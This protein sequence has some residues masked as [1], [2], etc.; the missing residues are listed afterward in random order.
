MTEPSRA[1]GSPAAASFRLYF[2]PVLLAILNANRAALQGSRGDGELLF[3]FSIA[4]AS[5]VVAAVTR[6]F[7]VEASWNVFAW[8]AG[9]T[10][11]A[12]S[13]AIIRNAPAGHP[14]ALYVAVTVCVSALLVRLDRVGLNN[15]GRAET[16][17]TATKVP[18][19]R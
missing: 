14:V 5:F 19:R 3:L 18:V 2:L 10:A 4:A 11:A 12:S 7:S 16:R 9:L 8:A 6:R 13:L 15:P 1:E 17:S